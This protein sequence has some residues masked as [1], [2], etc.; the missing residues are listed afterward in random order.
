MKFNK[1][2]FLHIG[3]N[4]TGT[5]Y[6]QDKLFRNAEVLRSN[7]ICYPV[8]F[9]AAHHELAALAQKG[10]RVELNQWI[11]K[12]HHDYP[13]C[14]RVILSS[15]AFVQK[16]NPEILADAF[17]S[18]VQ[19]YCIVRDI[20]SHLFSWYKQY[21]QAQLGTMS[22][23]EF[24]LY[25]RPFSFARILSDWKKSFPNIIVDQYEELDSSIE[26][27]IHLAGINCDLDLDEYRNNPSIQDATAHLAPLLNAS[28]RLAQLPKGEIYQFYDSVAHEGKGW[29]RFDV[30]E[31]EVM[32]LIQRFRHR[33]VSQEI[34]ADVK[35]N[36]TNEIFTAFSEPVRNSAVQS[37]L[38]SVAVKEFLK[39][40]D[41]RGVYDTISVM[42]NVKK[43]AR[44]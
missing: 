43:S 38:Q 15:E 29:Q 21:L 37:F 2:F 30:V 11:E 24:L 28:F 25:S 14:D 31:S 35:P 4:K 1:K 42:T 5:S 6:I 22:F 12:L 13:D 19:I 8:E 16:A 18:D 27:I 33:E 34:T 40:D 36:N 41:F 26:N 39:S 23:K 17:G 32:N 7:G 20:G 44:G 10:K 3:F 9:G